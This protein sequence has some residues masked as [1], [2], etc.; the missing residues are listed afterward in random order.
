M[1]D[2]YKEDR[3]MKLIDK[4]QDSIVDVVPGRILVPTRVDP[5]TVQQLHRSCVHF[6]NAVRIVRLET[7]NL[8][9]S[10]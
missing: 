6:S 5:R 2:S 10:N 3:L 4:A 7:A 8:I 1:K 9:H